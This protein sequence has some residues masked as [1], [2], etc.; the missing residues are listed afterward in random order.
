M[1]EDIDSNQHNIHS[2]TSFEKQENTD[3]R[4]AQLIDDLNWGYPSLTSYS[5][6]TIDGG[7]SLQQYPNNEDYGCPLPIEAS[8]SLF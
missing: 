2:P 7:S 8:D 4:D 1:G 3:G 6:R 5:V